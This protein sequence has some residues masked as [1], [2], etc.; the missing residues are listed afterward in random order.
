MTV[1]STTIQTSPTN[2]YGEQTSTITS[3]RINDHSGSNF[4][5]SDDFEDRGVQ[6][7]DGKTGDRKSVYSATDLDPSDIVRVE[8]IQ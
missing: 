7:I 1:Y 4:V 3:E 8:G 6:V 2:F 5:S